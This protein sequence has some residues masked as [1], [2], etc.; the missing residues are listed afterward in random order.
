MF[1]NIF[2]LWS[3]L[4]NRHVQKHTKILIVT[5]ITFTPGIVVMDLEF[6]RLPSTDALGR[7]SSSSYNLSLP[8]FTWR[9]DFNVSCDD[10]CRNVS[11]YC[12]DSGDVLNAERTDPAEYGW[13]WQPT[14]QCEYRDDQ[15]KPSWL[16]ILWSWSSLLY[17]GTGVFRGNWKLTWSYNCG[18]RG[19]RISSWKFTLSI[20]YSYRKRQ[21]NYIGNRGGDKNTWY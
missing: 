4:V 1:E 13:R 2:R 5:Q 18:T 8:P 6:Q 19:F 7:T 10:S 16:P 15:R 20:T 3:Y 11:N 12:C 21:P 17:N 14:A 9:N